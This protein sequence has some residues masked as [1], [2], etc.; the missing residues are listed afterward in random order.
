MISLSSAFPDCIVMGPVCEENLLSEGV[1]YM[2]C[3]ITSYTFIS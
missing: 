3:I 2:A 1:H